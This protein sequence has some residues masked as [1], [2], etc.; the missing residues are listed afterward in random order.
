MGALIDL[1]GQRFGSLTAVVRLPD[2]VAPS[3]ARQPVWGCVCACGRRTIEQGRAL[4]AGRATSC[5]EC[6]RDPRRMLKFGSTYLA[7]WPQLGILK[8]G[9]AFRG[10]RLEMLRR[11]G[12]QI[13][14]NE[15]GTDASWEA[16]GL[17]VL[18]RLFDRAFTGPSGEGPH[19]AD[20]I[21]Y[22]GR[23]W[24]ECFFVE[25]E[26][27]ELAFFE[28]LRAFALEGN[29]IGSN[30]PATVEWRRELDAVV[31]ARAAGR[32]RGDAGRVAGDRARGGA[33]PATAGDP[34]GEDLPEPPTG[35]GAGGAD[36]ARRDA[37]RRRLCTLVDRRRPRVAAADRPVGDPCSGAAE[38][39]A[40]SPIFTGWGERGRR[41]T[42]AR[43]RA[44]A[45][46]SAGGSRRAGTG[47][48]LGSVVSGSGSTGVSSSCQTVAAG[49]PTDR[50]SG[51]SSWP[52]RTLRPVRYSGG[53]PAGV[54]G[55]ERVHRAAVD[56]RG[57]VGGARR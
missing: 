50:V 57:A 5:R 46:E 47:G 42:C 7:Y 30:P 55:P 4:R 53:A 52:L 39:P 36:P 8:I 45:R 1:A 17:R 2:A 26:D 40:A 29:E 10:S 33:D 11:S 43:E 49:C 31:R 35:Y 41:S 27:L 51:S 34:R 28:C 54:A 32:S 14:L 3:G 44:G 38:R 23:G 19:R 22:R 48:P 21:L 18:S 6:V 20:R 13:L 24:S 9:R 56:L 16:A 25:P 12:A 15:W 37:R